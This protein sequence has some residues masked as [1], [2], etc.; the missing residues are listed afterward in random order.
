[1][2]LF[3]LIGGVGLIASS[4][5]IFFTQAAA[6]QQASV[7]LAVE[8]P[9]DFSDTTVMAKSAYVFDINEGKALFKKNA[10]AQLPLASI[11]KIPV[12][13]LAKK[14]L[15]PEEMI[16]ITPYAL[17][18]EGDWGFTIGDSWRVRDL[19]DYTLMT[20]SNDGA[21]ALA[22]SIEIETGKKIV[23]LLDEQVS[24]IGLQQ[25]YFLNETGLDSSIA[26]SGAYGSAQDI[27]ALFAHAYAV[28][29]D[30]LMA[31]AISERTY[32]SAEGLEYEAKNTN[33]AIGQLPGL[34]FGKTGFTDLAGGNLAVV[35]ESEPGHPF[36]IV[37]LGSTLEERFNDVVKLTRATLRTPA[38]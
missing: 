18:P 11:A 2:A 32:Y 4:L 23:T 30:T 22:E 24:E 8:Q 9:Y 31:T 16:T 14:Y 33:K 15:D 21:A 12:A 35:T 25:T 29:P 36:V 20:S 1:M 34:V 5:N 7:V 19:I 13:L 38:K 3:S 37:V 6:T 26:F 10:E 27:G 28:A 17:T